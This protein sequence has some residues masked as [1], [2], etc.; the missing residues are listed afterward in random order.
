M[1]LAFA[2]L[3][4]KS[5]L[6]SL[7]DHFVIIEDWREPWRVAHPLREGNYGAKSKGELVHQSMSRASKMTIRR[8][9]VLFCRRVFSYCRSE[10]YFCVLKA[11]S[12]AVFNRA[13]GE[14]WDER[15]SMMQWWADYLDKL[16]TPAAVQDA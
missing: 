10:F 14:H 9:M 15:V 4:E 7:L 16:R 5:R 6:K 11:A 3:K 2:V 1:G 8:R 13:R 12:G